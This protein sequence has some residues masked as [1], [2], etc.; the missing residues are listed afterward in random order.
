MGSKIKNKTSLNNI[1][2]AASRVRSLVSAPPDASALRHIWPRL[3]SAKRLRLATLVEIDQKSYKR[4]ISMKKPKVFIFVICF[5]LFSCITLDN[6]RNIRFYNIE[7]DIIES[8]KNE[9]C[10][11]VLKIGEVKYDDIMYPIWLI[12]YI[13]SKI[14]MYSVLNIG[15]LHG[16]EPG[17]VEVVIKLLEVCKNSKPEN[18]AYDFIYCMNP[19]GYLYNKRENGNGIDLN[20]DFKNMKSQEAKIFDNY[21]KG[22][23]YDIV[24]DHH[25]NPNTDGFS[26]IIQNENSKK[27]IQKKIEQFVLGGYKEAKNI[28]GVDN[29]EN[30]LTILPLGDGK[31]FSQYAGINICNSEKVFVIETPTKW[32][33]LERIKFHIEFEKV[34]ENE[35]LK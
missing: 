25:E 10:F 24:I 29:Y 21:L 7:K 32:E 20:R 35:Y 16:N 5:S 14:S 13:P 11:Q 27:V 12:K 22:K 18:I 2:K 8:I 31:G 23:N 30:G 28:N 26:I 3:C 6:N 33:M 4:I 9:S 1:V 17:G 15:G 34:L 19:W